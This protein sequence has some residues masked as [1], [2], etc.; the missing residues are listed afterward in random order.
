MRRRSVSASRLWRSQQE[1]DRVKAGAAGTAD[2]VRAA[3]RLNDARTAHLDALTAVH[4]ARVA[5]AAAMGD[6]TELP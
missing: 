6:V 4:A 5:L 3:L 1:E 2:V